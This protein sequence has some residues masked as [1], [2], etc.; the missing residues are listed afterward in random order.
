MYIHIFLKKIYIYFKEIV[1]AL[2]S[3]WNS[4]VRRDKNGGR[5]SREDHI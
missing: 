5:E 1:Y 2:F 4:P 3:D